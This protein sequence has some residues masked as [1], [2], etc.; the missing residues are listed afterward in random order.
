MA[1]GA[2]GVADRAENCPGTVPI[3]RVGERH[4]GPAKLHAEP[5]EVELEEERREGCHGLDGR[6][7]VVVEPRQGELLGSTPSARDGRPLEHLHPESGACQHQRGRQ[8]I[9]PGSDDDGVRRAQR[10][11]TSQLEHQ[12]LC[13]DD[14]LRLGASV[15]DECRRRIAI[16]GERDTRGV[17]AV[18]DEALAG[19]RRRASD[20]QEMGTH[21]SQPAPR[22][23]RRC[24]V[25]SS[26]S[27]GRSSDSAGTEATRQAV[28]ATSEEVR[29]PP[30]R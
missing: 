10:G 28:T 6:A 25:D 24:P 16:V 1:K 23:S 9:R 17:P 30:S 8:T 11:R 27:A 20:T 26:S 5:L 7:D 3:E 13:G 4:L 21:P 14:D 12:R 22:S 29:A 2:C 19:R 15:E 18:A